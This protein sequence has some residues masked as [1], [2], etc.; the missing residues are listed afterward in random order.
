[1]FKHL[2]RTPFNVIMTTLALI[3]FLSVSLFAWN[4]SSVFFVLIGGVIGIV[5]YLICGLKKDKNKSVD[6]KEGE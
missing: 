2:K 6:D 5:T 1:M 4:F 3:A